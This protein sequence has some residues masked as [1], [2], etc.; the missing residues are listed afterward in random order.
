MLP[1]SYSVLTSEASGLFFLYAWLPYGHHQRTRGL[2]RAITEC[3]AC[4]ENI[5]NFW[6]DFLCAPDQSF[7]TILGVKEIPDPLNDNAIATVLVVG[8]L[9][10]YESV[11]DM[12]TSCADTTYVR[13]YP[14]IG[15]PA[16]FVT[17]QF[18]TESTGHGLYV[19]VQVPPRC[20]NRGLRWV[21]RHAIRT[22]CKKLA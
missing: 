11:Q 8:A 19:D 17:Y 21:E 18:Q 4:A 9:I 7:A 16:D 6:C 2:R 10:D 14:A 20:S 3:P 5:Q 13:E 15:N 12:F 1:L 22:D